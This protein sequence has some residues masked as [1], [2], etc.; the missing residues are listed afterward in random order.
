MSSS[1]PLRFENPLYTIAEAA[2]IVDVPPS[3][4]T[5][6][7]KGYVRR[8]PGRPDV[9]GDPIITYRPP[10]APREPSI[11]FVGLAEALVLAAVRR[12]G[13]PLQRIR[14]A[15]AA[16]E[17]QLGVAH[18]LASERLFTDGAEV[19]FDYG[20]SRADSLE[21]QLV[22]N[23][24]VVRSGQRVFTDVISSYL[25]KIEYAPDG[26]AEL[27]HLPAYRT[28][29]VVADPSRSFGAPVL[30]RGGARIEDI[31]ERFWTGESI[32]GLSLEFGAPEPQLEDV[33]RVAS[34]RA[35]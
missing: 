15:I 4:L 16:L 22:L 31:L 12:S 20:E 19:L 25:R 9:S 21:G 27:I 8:F 17:R 13:V 2:R 29:E 1:D 28:A 5:T 34:R 14:P 24:V 3:T 26:Y 11:P 23:L 18:A 35:A 10:S 30:E 6:W 7:A 33:I 32:R